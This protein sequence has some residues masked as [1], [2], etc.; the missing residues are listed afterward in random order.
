MNEQ[1]ISVLKAFEQLVNIIS[2]LEGRKKELEGEVVGLSRERKDLISALTTL[3]EEVEVKRKKL[4]TI[5]SDLRDL[6]ARVS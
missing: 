3:T 4:V 6:K 2:Q 5:D 1:Q